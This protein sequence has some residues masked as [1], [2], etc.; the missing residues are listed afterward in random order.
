MVLAEDD[1][2]IDQYGRTAGAV[3]VL[4]W[5]HSMFPKLFAVEI[6]AD[7]AVAAEKYK[8]PLSITRGRGRCRTADLMGLLNTRHGEGAPPQQPSVLLVERDRGQ[9]LR[10]GATGGDE[11]FAVHQDRR[12]MSGIHL[13]PPAQHAG[14]IKIIRQRSNA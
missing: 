3:F 10:P 6:V 8:H 1:F 11:D 12:G 4:E 2:V 9:L 14:R 7:Q 13:D 5:T